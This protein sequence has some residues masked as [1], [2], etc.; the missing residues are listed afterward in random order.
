M[1]VLFGFILVFGINIETCDF[2]FLRE[3]KMDSKNL[4]YL[5]FGTR[6][7]QNVL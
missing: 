4:T 7:V 5:L 2:D 1:F 3:E 6:C